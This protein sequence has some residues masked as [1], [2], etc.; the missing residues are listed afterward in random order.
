MAEEKETQ[1]TKKTTI[2]LPVN[3]L[4][5]IRGL[6]ADDPRLKQGRII[7]E[8]IKKYLDLR[9]SLSWSESKK[10]A[11][12]IVFKAQ[13]SADPEDS[14]EFPVTVENLVFLHQSC[15]EAFKKLGVSIPDEKSS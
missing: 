11:E 15:H 12:E 4:K 9:T 5:Q 1:I 13:I 2:D 6:M 10:K 3:L 7:I 14:L 8:A